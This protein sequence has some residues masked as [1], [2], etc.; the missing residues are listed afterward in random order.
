MRKKEK[1]NELV[2]E[3]EREQVDWVIHERKRLI[4][5]CCCCCCWVALAF[6]VYT[7]LYTLLDGVDCA[8]HLKSCAQITTRSFPWLADRETMARQL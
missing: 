1:R 8:I 4:S 7:L 2:A 3:R 6:F 5:E